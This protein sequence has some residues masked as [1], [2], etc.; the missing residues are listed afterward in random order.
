ML[1]FDPFFKLDFVLLI[2][3]ILI[4][5]GNYIIEYTKI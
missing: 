3:F 5:F 4:Y 1:I 2:F